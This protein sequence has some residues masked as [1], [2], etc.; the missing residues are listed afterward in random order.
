MTTPVP[1]IM[2]AVE[3]SAYDGQ[4][5]SIYVVDRRTPR[6]GRGEVLVQIA[7]APINPSDLEFLM[8]RHG[9]RKHLPIIPG[10]EGSGTVVAAGGGVA[11]RALLGR[12]VAVA[13]PDDGDG[14]WAEY[15]VTRTS[16]CIPLAPATDMDAGAMIVI[17]PLTAWALFDRCAGDGHSAIVLTAAAG[18]LGKMMVRG[19]MKR[20]ITLLAVVRN[21]EQADSL[22]AIGADHVLSVDDLHFEDKLRTACLT[23]SATIAFD[24]IGG[25]MVPRLL[26]ALPHGGRVVVIGSFES[27]PVTIEPSELLYREKK[28]EGFW[29]SD[30]L[31]RSPVPQ[32]LRAS[33]AV[34]SSLGDEYATT[35]RGRVPLE[36]VR[37][38]IIDYSQAMSRGKYLF[39][40]SLRP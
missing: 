30:W 10:F 24:A 23:L 11:G 22:R 37:E 34:Q 32:V 14:T 27:G 3:I 29:L 38:A 39:V 31:D 12:R 15:V 18:A 4:L 36:S 7:A 6:P 2:R 19:A 1:S 8:G 33:V 20:G 28:I 25:E 13:S 9:T 5:S 40:P 16:L 17:N 21:A 26:T 35:V